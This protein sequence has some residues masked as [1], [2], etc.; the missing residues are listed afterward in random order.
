MAYSMQQ[1]QLEA[2]LSKVLPDPLTASLTSH[3]IMLLGFPRLQKLRGAKYIRGIRC[4][5]PN[6][7]V[8]NPL[9]D[10]RPL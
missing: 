2:V 6:S 8:L 1:G 9:L 5:V 7:Q 3:N 4:R 10:A